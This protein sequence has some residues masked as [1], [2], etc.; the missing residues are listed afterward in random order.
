MR[1]AL[2]FIVILTSPMFGQVGIGTTSPNAA[3]DITATNDGLLLPRIALNNTTTATVTT[4]TVSEL[5]YNTA[6]A[7]TTP[8]DVVPGYYYW[9]GSKWLQL[10]TNN[11]AVSGAYWSLTGNTISDTDYIGTNNYKPFNI[12]AGGTLLGS[13]HPGGSIKLGENTVGSN[14]NAFAI[15]Y[16]ANSATSE[17]YA[18]GSS[19]WAN[20]WRSLALGSNTKTDGA[21]SVA[22]G[23]FAS[24]GVLAANS[25]A[26]GY[27]AT[28]TANE[29]FAIGSKAHASGDNSVAL[30]FNSVSSS[31]G[32]SFAT[33]NFL[34]QSSNIP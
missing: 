1:K 26:I 8:N 24:T 23:N 31:T 9:D 10:A 19:A 16:G 29:A 22:I 20:S 17:S 32:F 2:L 4:P 5:V 33:S 27:Y 21:Y 18:F 12:K 25:I 34:T 11:S 30:G 7:G 6:T 13:F 14:I 3:L 15:G 28:T